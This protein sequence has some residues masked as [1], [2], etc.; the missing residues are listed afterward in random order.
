MPGSGCRGQRRSRDHGFDAGHG[1]L[2]VDAT[3]RDFHAHD[4]VDSGSALPRLFRTPRLTDFGH[5]WRDVEF[6][7]LAHRLDRG[8]ATLRLAGSTVGGDLFPL[9]DPDDIPNIVLQT[10]TNAGGT[11]GTFDVSGFSGVTTCPWNRSGPRATGS[12]PARRRT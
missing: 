11:N 5:H 2:C 1:D 9:A 10:L 7:R 6:V 3:G 8:T 4:G 12:R